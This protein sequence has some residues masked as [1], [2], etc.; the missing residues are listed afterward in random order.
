MHRQRHC[1]EQQQQ[2]QRRR[3]GC[4][5]NCSCSCIASA[6]LSL[7]PQRAAASGRCLSS[8][9][10]R[11]HI[12]EQRIEDR[13]LCCHVAT[14]ALA[15]AV[16]FPSSSARFGMAVFVWA[17]PPV[18]ARPPC[19]WSER[20]G[21]ASQQRSHTGAGREAKACGA[22][23]CEWSGRTE[24]RRGEGTG[25][26]SGHSDSA[27]HPSPV[28]F[29]LLCCPSL[30]LDAARSLQQLHAP[31]L[32][33]VTS[34]LCFTE[35]PASLSHTALHRSDSESESES[36]VVFACAVPSARLRSP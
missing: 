34:I 14:R 21:A 19:C 24:R 5:C 27:A 22:G 36:A 28:A 29:C 18:G 12:F 31:A 4:N 25:A 10:H 3:G 2:Q 16:I 6:S 33:R 15:H 20:D 11:L 23:V 26:I 7:N 30:G 8:A 17:W 35:P 9:S 1:E 13:Q 32:N